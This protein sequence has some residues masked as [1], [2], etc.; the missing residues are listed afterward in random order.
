M[1]KLKERASLDCNGRVRAGGKGDGRS[2]NGRVR[3]K[4]RTGK[5]TY[6]SAV[7]RGVSSREGFRV[8]DAKLGMA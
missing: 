6:K 1:W 8:K 5:E 4:Q 2:D 7:V 3:D